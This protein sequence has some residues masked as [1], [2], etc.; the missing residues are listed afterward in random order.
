M[1]EWQMIAKRLDGHLVTVGGIDHR[2]VV[3]REPSGWFTTRVAAHPVN[4]GPVIRWD[5]VPAEVLQQCVP[6]LRDVVPCSL[7]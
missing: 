5:V 7:A 4:Y 6:V 1:A 3:D 2:L